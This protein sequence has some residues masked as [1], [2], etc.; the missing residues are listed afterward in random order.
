MFADLDKGRIIE[1]K[2]TKRRANL[3][4]TQDGKENNVFFWYGFNILYLQEVHYRI[5]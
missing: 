5:C 2:T 4:H 3:Y 1:E